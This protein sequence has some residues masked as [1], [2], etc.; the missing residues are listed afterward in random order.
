MNPSNPNSTYNSIAKTFKE[1][2]L[3]LLKFVRLR[4]NSLEDAEDIVQDVFY[5]F[6]QVNELTQSVEQ[7]AAWLYRV[8][9]NKIIDTYKK[10]KSI[11]FSSL[12]DE[13]DM[14]SN[15]IS[16][17]IDILAFQENTPETEALHSFIWEEIKDAID[18]LP[19]NQRDV[20]I[21]TEFEGLSVKEISTKTGITVNTLLSR[22]HYAVK[23]L[24]EKLKCLYEDLISG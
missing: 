21:Q 11:P 22:K 20:F 4:V 3:N 6:A 13:N 2:S 5:K 14:Y 15:D 16:D 24:R 18:D 9:R 8:A 12:V 23:A 19:E 1:Y 10:K 7:T 17:I